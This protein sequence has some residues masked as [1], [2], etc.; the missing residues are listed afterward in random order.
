M[1][2]VG[3]DLGWYY[4]N[5]SRLQNAADAAV[6]AGAKKLIEAH[7][8]FQGKSYKNKLVDKY[9]K[10]ENKLAKDEDGNNISTT[11]GDLEALKYAKK[12]LGDTAYAPPSLFSVAQAADDKSTKDGYT[13]GDNTVTMT[14]NLYQDG[15][16]YFYVVGLSENIHHFFIG[17]LDD[18]N[19]G[20]VAVALLSKNIDDSE[21]GNPDPPEQE[22]TDKKI[23]LDAN[24]GSL[25]DE[26][27]NTN[28]SRRNVAV[29]IDEDNNY[30]D[31]S[32]PKAGAINLQKEGYIFKGWN[33]KAD[34]TG[35]SYSDGKIFSAD[36]LETLL[37]DGDVVLYAQWEL[38]QEDIEYVEEGASI[39]GA[40]KGDKTKENNIRKG[41]EELMTYRT[42]MAVA[43]ELYS[44]GTVTVSKRIGTGS[45][46]TFTE[47]INSM[48][49]AYWWADYVPTIT[50]AKSGSSVS[51]NSSGYRQEI[52]TVKSEIKKEGKENNK[53]VYYDLSDKQTIF[54]DLGADLNY[55]DSN[56]SGKGL[57]K[58]SW[59]VSDAQSGSS[60]KNSITAKKN[61]WVS[62]NPSLTYQPEIS[63]MKYRVHTN[64][65]IDKNWTVR[66]NQT[67]T[68][69]YTSYY[70]SMGESVPD[71]PKDPLY[72]RIESEELNE[73]DLDR[74]NTTVR[75]IN[76]NINVSNTG[77]KDRPLV[78]FYEGPDRGLTEA[79]DQAEIS[80]NQTVNPKETYGE[81]TL[82]DPQPLVLNLNA[83]FRGILF[84]PNSPVIIKGNGHKFE[85]FV[86]AKEFYTGTTSSDSYGS[87]KGIGNPTKRRPVEGELPYNAK[88]FDEFRATYYNSFTAYKQKNFDE[89][90]YVYE[91]SSF[92]LSSASHYDWFDIPELERTIY[93]YLNPDTSRDM[94]FTTVRSKWVT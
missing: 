8:L 68:D 21:G 55:K 6:L 58:Y 89:Y 38:G 59:D 83:D 94:F 92:N 20:V 43:K 56:S 66:K 39:F 10:D 51:Y 85:G 67:K 64:I 65:N 26:S 77:E 73:A 76:I 36:V 88:S 27:G 5:V 82:R 61:D 53:D 28:K 31:T 4:L 29:N 17:F 25:I 9:P 40:M 57:F 50:P 75:Q 46:T 78:I 86:V 24:E 62:S 48:D 23:I 60:V 93:T 52:L 74:Q 84:A 44:T 47:G 34:G 22:L 11:D 7:A 19:A 33:T 2:G 70:T 41:L 13:R 18:M 87:L 49:D 32:L 69:K 12:N 30:E 42:W 71:S 35:T 1:G 14:T 16:D 72:M 91:M 37:A 3:L 45:Y 15:E 90:E 79:Y 80:G 81:L 54:L 63:Y